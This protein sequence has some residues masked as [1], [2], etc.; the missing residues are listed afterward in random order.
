MHPSKRTRLVVAVITTLVA[1]GI[2]AVGGA[3]AAQEQIRLHLGSDGQYFSFGSTTQ[4]LTTGKNTCKINSA[5]PLID[6]SS[7]GNTAPGLG[8]DS[9]IGVRSN[10]GGNGTPCSQVD[11]S[12]ALTLSPGSQLAGRTFTGVRLDLEVT[13]NAV[14]QLRLA[15]GAQSE[16]YL[17]Q[18][19]T[20]IQPAQA[21]E[22]DYDATAPYAASSSPGDS[23]DACAAPNSSGPNSGSNDNCEWTVQAGFEFD[24]MTLT[25]VQDGT[26]SLEGSGDFG[27]DPNH[28]TIFY[29]SN[30]A[31][32]ANDDTVTTN[33]DTAVSGNVLTNDSDPE[34]N[35]LTAS[36]LTNPSHGTATLT[37]TGAF[38]YTPVLNYNGSDSFTYAASDGSL[39]SNATVRITV[40]PVNDP[41]VAQNGT[42]STNEDQK[43]TVTVATD[44]DSTSLTST[45]TGAAGGTVTDNGNGTIDYT[46]APNF[47]GT[48]TLSCTS[49][50][51]KG[52][53]TS[54]SATITVG[55]TPV[56]DAPVARDDTAET[57]QNVS[58]AIAVL[59]NDTD[60]DGDALSPVSIGNVTPL[61][62]IAVANANGTVTFTPPTGFAGSASF[63]Y[64]ASDGA[65][66]S[67][68]ATVNVAVFPVI[69]S[70]ETVTDTDGDVTGSFT[71]LDDSF[72]CKRYTLQASQADG[73]V[74]FKPTGAASVD[75]RGFV[76][77]DPDNAPA[78]PGPFS[79]LLEYDPTGG[80]TF[81]PVTW[82]IN[83][84]FSGNLV[85]TATL[86]AGETWC[87]AAADTRPNTT[88]KIVTVW[89][90]FGR[91]D[92]RFR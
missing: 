46:P 22:P 19:G 25:T 37:P 42:T 71:R 56:N 90:V 41:P 75:Y 88:G 47:N 26:V 39:S 8:P 70:T 92:P 57:N 79:L 51:D 69:C 64:R 73:T 72:D 29:L 83:P 49:T 17:L 91:D 5:E 34:G 1:V 44:V 85:T 36:L 2:V 86:P 6:L 27:N 12:E 66:T 21:A 4:T 78:P 14:V 52:A 28:D 40:T 76:T 23:T 77:T 43:V 87:I 13:G 31:P 74:L 18:T 38:T 89:Q 58:V 11:A 53:S 60:V 33:E 32:S 9:S 24:T 3:G 10:S 35:P 16:T 15:R 45:C 30:R 81:R 84:Q 20:N 50:D 63:T 55:V 61:G 82:C 7:P 80:S 48:V 54:S 68:V 67:N 65:L 62:S 59:A